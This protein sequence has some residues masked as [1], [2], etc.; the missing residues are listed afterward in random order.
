MNSE[1]NPCSI[2][3][4][5]NLI[6]FI[7]VIVLFIVLTIGSVFGGNRLPFYSRE[8]H[9]IMR[10]QLNLWLVSSVQYTVWKCRKTH[11]IPSHFVGT[12]HPFVQ[13]FRSTLQ[14]Y[15][16]HTRYINHKGVDLLTINASQ[17]HSSSHTRHYPS[18]MQDLVR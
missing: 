14:E 6:F 8:I 13:L 5:S 9:I 7:D 18:W 17:S 11:S 10:E 1:I 16:P 15:H 2:T 12:F 4:P 3:Q